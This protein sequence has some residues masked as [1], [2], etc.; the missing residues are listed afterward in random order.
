MVE[1]LTEFTL[2]LFREVCAQFDLAEAPKL[3]PPNRG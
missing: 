3:G 1:L 2:A